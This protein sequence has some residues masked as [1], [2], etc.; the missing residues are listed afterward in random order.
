[1]VD[2]RVD[3]RIDGRLVEGPGIF[4]QSGVF[5]RRA[6]GVRRQQN[7]P[8]PP[9]GAA[10]RLMNY[11]DCKTRAEDR[12]WRALGT[13]PGLKA[14]DEQLGPAM[15]RPNRNQDGVQGGSGRYLGWC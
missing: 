10:L 12:V 11:K 8:W 9:L 2:E 7:P 4:D 14:P 6:K 3:E 15:H 5:G 1:M 13:R